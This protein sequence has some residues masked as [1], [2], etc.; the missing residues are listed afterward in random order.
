MVFKREQIQCR[1]SV[2]QVLERLGSR[3][4]NEARLVAAGSHYHFLAK[5]QREEVVL[6]FRDYG[7]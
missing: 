7:S 2:V 4:K 1:N 3:E 5:G 6:L